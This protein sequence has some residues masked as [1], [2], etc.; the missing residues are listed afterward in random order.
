MSAAIELEEKFMSLFPDSRFWPTPL[1]P[2]QQGLQIRR[3]LERTTDDI[4]FSNGTGRYVQCSCE[5][6]T[7]PEKE[8]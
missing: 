5:N 4:I 2:E 6:N 3:S 7:V 8:E 1:P